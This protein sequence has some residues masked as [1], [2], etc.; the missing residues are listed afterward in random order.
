MNYRHCE[1]Q[2]GATLFTLRLKNKGISANTTDL[3]DHVTAEDI[4]ICQEGSVTITLPCLFGHQSRKWQR[5]EEMSGDR[6]PI[7]GHSRTLRG[8]LVDDWLSYPV[9]VF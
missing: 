8:T 2:Q 4:F 5:R 1:C 3:N 9:M 6:K 7:N